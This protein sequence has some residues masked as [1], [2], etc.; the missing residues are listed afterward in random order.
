MG[1]VY[2]LRDLSAAAFASVCGTS[3]TLAEIIRRI[4]L[5]ATSTAYRDVKRRARREG[6]S[7][8][9]VPRGLGSNA[10]RPNPNRSSI[11]K[12][13]A[14]G[15]RGW[16]KNAIRR[17]N[18]MPYICAICEMPPVWNGQPLTLR[19]DHINGDPSDNR[20]SNL[21][22]ACPNCDSQLPTFAG[23]NSKTSTR[24]VDCGRKITPGCARC[25]ACQ[26][27]QQPTKISWPADTDLRLEVERTGY[28]A[29]A[30]RLGVSDK[31]VKKRLMKRFIAPS[32]RGPN[33][34]KLRQ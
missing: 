8:E 24:C 10:G 28:R 14:S 16:I 33:R 30:A 27:G 17:D 12:I 25:A 2:R 31:A 13:L 18:L 9:H 6:V 5:T 21:R 15:N 20:L 3:K 4:G 22:F 1:R 34:I 7:L 11:E 26:K 32:F 23:R 19:L 29:T